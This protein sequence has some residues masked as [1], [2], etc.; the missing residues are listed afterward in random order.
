MNFLQLKDRPIRQKLTL[1]TLLASGVAL[2]IAAFAFVGY[3]RI[4]FR[5]T[6]VSSISASAQMLGYNSISALSFGDSASAEQTLKSLSQQPHVVAACLYDV[7]GS[8]FATYVRDDRAIAWPKPQPWAEKFSDDTLDVM[9]SI[10]SSEGSLGVIFIQSDLEEMRQRM[11]RYVLIVFAVLLS[12]TLVAL[13]IASRL[14]K[15]ISSPILRL[16]ELANIVG[17]ERNYHVRAEKLGDD[18]VGQLMDGFNEMLR[19]IQQRETELQHSRDELENRVRERT[20]QL[21]REIAERNR[22]AEQVAVSEAFLQSLLENLPIA[23]YRKDPEGKIIFANSQYC[24]NLGKPLADIIGRSDFELIS[25]EQA[26]R[27]RDEDVIVMNT[28]QP[29]HAVV[30]DDRGPRRRWIHVTKVAVFGSDKRIIGTQGILWDIT[31]RKQTEEALKAAKEAAE[32]AAQAKTDFL[33]NMSH[34]IRTP[35][36]GVI[37]LTGLLLETKLEPVQR[38]FAETVRRSAESLLNIVND[39]LDFSKVDAGKMTFEKLEFD[40]LETVESTIDMMA[41][42]AQMKG[43]ELLDFVEPE[44]PS[45]LIGDPGRLR[46]VLLNLVGNAVKFTDSGEVSLRIRPVTTDEHYV[47]LRFEVRDTGIGINPETQRLLF[48]PFTQADTSTTRRFGGTGLGLA[49]AKRLVKMMQGEIGVKSAP[50][51]GTTFWFTARFERSARPA[52]PDLAG[53]DLGGKHILIFDSNATL[54]DMLHERLISWKAQADVTTSQQAAIELAKGRASRHEPFD[55]V[56]F[57]PSGDRAFVSDAVQRMAAVLDPQ[58]TRL[59]L[60]SSLSRA[61]ENEAL[62][63][64]GVSEVL[65]KPVK[66]AR[67]IEALLR[68]VGGSAAPLPSIRPATTE[69]LTVELPKLRVLVAEDNVVNQKVVL[70]QLKR[71]GCVADVVAN[72][73]EILTAV[74]RVKYDV[75]LMDCQMPEMDGYEATRA[76]RRAELSDPTRVDPPVY[77][78]AQTANAMPGDREKCLLAGMNDYVSKPLR[79][80]E[81]QRALRRAVAATETHRELAAKLSNGD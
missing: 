20:E 79:L 54:G 60:L 61:A 34:E 35:M 71:L 57:D 13:F 72:G 36:N 76:L 73:F 2:M 49:I 3:E 46:Q 22:I 55:V 75:V 67:L 30:A 41:E 28:G 70:G 1:L 8:V 51:F 45:W 24:E 53:P 43:L 25:F 37:G 15:A 31:E 78:I 47:T 66:R 69:S 63:S 9:R 17:S 7:K 64:L 56:I 11:Q 68:G 33:A 29:H 50:G 81:L 80:D 48:Q 58:R 42:R 32:I 14:Q 65:V 4:M 40:L 27:S 19:E 62:R 44:V 16:A 26:K 52:K 10:D 18:E 6:M 21:V 38:E 59:I 74:Q 39:V 23:L 77:I 12:S 5:R